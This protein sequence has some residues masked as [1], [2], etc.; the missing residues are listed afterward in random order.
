[1]I[2][3]K[4][5]KAYII[6]E[7]AWTVFSAT[8]MIVLSVFLS[9]KESSVY[10][11]YNMIY[12]NISLLLNTVYFSVCYVLGQ[13]FYDNIEQ[14]K[15]IHDIYNSVFIGA[16]TILIS[17][18]YILTLPFVKLYTKGVTD[19]L[20]IHNILPLLFCLV[21]F[22]SWSRYVNGNLIGV[23]GKIKKIIWVNILEAVINLVSSIALVNV[24]GIVGV[25]FATVIALPL[26][27]I[28]CCY[29]SERII[30]KRKP[31][32]FLKICLGNLGFFS[33]VAVISRGININVNNYLDFFVYGI[34]FTVVITVIGA[35]VNLALNHDL[36]YV[37]KKLF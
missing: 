9:T 16:I 2:E 14:Y 19:V 37:I 26:K 23:A 27:V 29:V 33:L 20:Y 21:Q 3:L 28:Y 15:K 10:S 11:V 36:Y 18:A 34:L 31:I 17:V 5:R 25:L 13:T 7:I 1:M 6:T 35:V 32:R 8:D 12:S 4:D 30:L 24:F 22:L